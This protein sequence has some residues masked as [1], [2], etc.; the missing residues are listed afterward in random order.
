MAA[1]KSKKVQLNRRLLDVESDGVGSDV[2]CT[3]END[4]ATVVKAAL[5]VGAD[6][7]NSRVR[8]CFISKSEALRYSGYTC[9]RGMFDE[10]TLSTAERPSTSR[11]RNVSMFKTVFSPRDAECSLTSGQ[12]TNDRTFWALDIVQP[13]KK[14]NDRSTS[15]SSVKP[16]LLQTISKFPKSAQQI[17]ETTKDNDI[18]QTDIYDSNPYPSTFNDNIVLLGDAAHSVVHHFGQV[19][20][21]LK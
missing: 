6:G 17:I 14:L 2:R 20:I 5:V 18:L 19:C 21:F 9:W 3:F 15:S 11:R 8:E 4:T 12:V 7:V 1:L 16:M 13:E 10:K